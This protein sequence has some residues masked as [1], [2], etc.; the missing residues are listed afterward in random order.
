MPAYDLVCGIR[1][2]C[3][4]LA[5]CGLSDLQQSGPDLWFQI[6]ECHRQGGVG[7]P[8]YDAKARRKFGQ[9][10]KFCSLDLQGKSVRVGE[11][12]PRFVGQPIGDLEPQGRRLGERTSK[13][14]PVDE[15][16]A[17]VT[18]I[19][20]WTTPASL[21]ADQRDLLRLLPGNRRGKPQSHWCNGQ[22]RSAPA[23]P[24]TMEFRQKRLTDFEGEHLILLVR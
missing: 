22:A 8:F 12:S 13:A 21:R 5:P 15:R 18:P 23:L 10:G 6:A 7:L 3:C 1:R 20:R 16:G 9:W 2:R 17:F 19:Y 24:L 4:R 14:D 11:W